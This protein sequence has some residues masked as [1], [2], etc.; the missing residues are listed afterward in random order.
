MASDTPEKFPIQKMMSSSKY[1][2]IIEKI[3]RKETREYSL[4]WEDAAQ[5]AHEKVFQVLQA[6][7]FDPKKGNFY[8]WAATVARF[9]IIDLRRKERQ[10]NFRSLDQNIPGTD[11]PL[12]ETVADEFN[13]LDAVE[14]T[15][16]VFQVKEAIALLD[17]RHPHREYGKLWQGKVEGKTEVQIAA[18]F[19]ITQS[20]I[21]KRWKELRG[22]I[23]EELGLLPDVDDKLKGKSKKGRRTRS[24]LNW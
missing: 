23:A 3:A 1:Q 20:A 21:N 2:Q 13:L 4:S 10:R 7:K 14:Y 19:G 18:D 5:T 24:N 17:E 8:H 12:L 22:R 15:D 6:K 11:I 9:A 16:L